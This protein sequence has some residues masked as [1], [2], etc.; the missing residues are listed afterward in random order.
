MCTFLHDTVSVE[1]T[2]EYWCVLS[3]FVTLDTATPEGSEVLVG[4]PKNHSKDGVGTF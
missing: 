1:K 2:A 4:P 3:L